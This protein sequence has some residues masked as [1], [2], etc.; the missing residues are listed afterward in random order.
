MGENRIYKFFPFV[1]SRLCSLFKYINRM[2]E[3][4]YKIVDINLDCILVFE[5][6]QKK[7]GY[8]YYILTEQYRRDGRRKKWNDIEFLENRNAKF[9]KG[10]GEQLSK[11]EGA[12]DIFYYIYLT[13]YISI[14]EYE[15]LCEYRKKYL[16]KANAFRFIM[17]FVVVV[18]FPIAI[19]CKYLK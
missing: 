19:T 3:N 12:L 17:C 18:L 7:E 9:H 6:S 4:D 15:N 1:S 11:V 8:T 16:L 10:N 13:K 5:K 2:Y 14:E